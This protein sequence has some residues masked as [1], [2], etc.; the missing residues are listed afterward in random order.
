MLVMYPSMRAFRSWRVTPHASLKYCCQPMMRG[1]TFPGCQVTG[2]V[3][4]A[5]PANVI[6]SAGKQESPPPCVHD[7]RPPPAHGTAVPDFLRQESTHERGGEERAL[8]VEVV[9]ASPDGSRARPR[10]AR[11]SAMAWS[12]ELPFPR[13]MVSWAAIESATSALTRLARWREWTAWPPPSCPS[14]RSLR[15]SSPT[16][17]PS[18]TPARGGARAP[19]PDGILGAHPL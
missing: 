14:P 13:P 7:E 8:P 19:E 5:Q 9:A 10:S 15:R 1:W 16:P 3:A 6:H 18:I 11:W 2:A 17:T 12:G 4:V